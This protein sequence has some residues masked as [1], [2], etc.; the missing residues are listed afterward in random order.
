VLSITVCPGAKDKRRKPEPLPTSVEIAALPTAPSR[1]ALPFEPLGA[2]H[3]L[4]PPGPVGSDDGEVLADGELFMGSLGKNM[5]ALMLMV[6][7]L[8]GYRGAR[9]VPW[10]VDTSFRSLPRDERRRVLAGLQR[11]YKEFCRT[12]MHRQLKEH[13]SEKLKRSEES[14]DTDIKRERNR[15]LTFHQY[16]SAV[17]IV[18]LE[19]LKVL[20]AKY[21]G[22]G[23]DAEYAELLRNQFRVRQHC[24]GWKKGGLPAIGAVYGAE[25]LSR[26]EAGLR[27]VVV[28]VLVEPRRAP[29]KPKFTLRNTGGGES[30]LKVFLKNVENNRGSGRPQGQ[31]CPPAQPR[32][33]ECHHKS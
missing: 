19:L 24:H 33:Y 17:P 21:K 23:K 10:P 5:T 4:S 6:K 25:E 13:D 15:A 11:R 18:K 1:V 2:L 20:V 7:V 8:D 31:A 27:S 22:A 14:R 12:R 32:P 16:S 26:F 3:Q 28:M 9:R 30:N 29:V